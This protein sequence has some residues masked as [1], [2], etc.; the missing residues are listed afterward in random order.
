MIDPK[1]RPYFFFTDVT[2]GLVSNKHEISYSYNKLQDFLTFIQKSV[3]L[4]IC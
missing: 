4:H 1:S 2:N 3:F